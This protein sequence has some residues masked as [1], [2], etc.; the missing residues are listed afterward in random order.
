MGGGAGEDILGSMGNP[1]RSLV[2]GGEGYSRTLV[3]L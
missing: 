2:M 1:V 3:L